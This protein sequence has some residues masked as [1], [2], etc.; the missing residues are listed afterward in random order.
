M[1]I[2]NGFTVKEIA[3]QYVVIALGAA[4]KIFNGIIKLNESGKFIWDKLAEGAERDAIVEALLAEYEV[5]R[6]T[7]EADVDKFIEELNG[8]N[9]LE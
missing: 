8:A 4:S 7:A 3:G 2:K 9:I 5:D 6:A 1:K